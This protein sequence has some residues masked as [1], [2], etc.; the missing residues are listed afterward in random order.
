VTRTILTA[1]LLM[2]TACDKDVETA[3]PLPGGGPE[4]PERVIV[5]GIDA[6][7]YLAVLMPF[8]DVYNKTFALLDPRTGQ[9]GS[10]R[11][12]VFTNLSG[13]VTPSPDGRRVA[14]WVT[15]P[16]EGIQIARYAVEGGSPMLVMERLVELPIPQPAGAAFHWN[17]DSDRLYAQYGQTGFWIDADTGALH[18][19][20]RQAAPAQAIT[21][22]ASD[23]FLTPTHDPRRY[24]VQAAVGNT[25][26][27]LIYEDGEPVGWNAE[28]P[29]QGDGFNGQWASS[30][31]GQFMV[32]SGEGFVALTHLP[33]RTTTGLSFTATVATPYQE[34]AIHR[35]PWVPRVPQ[36]H[37]NGDFVTETGGLHGYQTRVEL[38]IGEVKKEDLYWHQQR[39]EPMRLVD[40]A[41]SMYADRLVV[42]RRLE[43]GAAALY[44]SGNGSRWQTLGFSPDG[45][46]SLLSMTGMARD[47][48]RIWPIGGA[49]SRIDHRDGSHQVLVNQDASDGMC[50][51]AMPIPSDDVRIDPFAAVA[52]LENGGL[53][54]NQVFTDGDGTFKLGPTVFGPSRI[55][56]TE[57]WHALLS[58]PDDPEGHVCFTKTA[59]PGTRHCLPV[60]G[61]YAAVLG[62]GGYAA[63]G[64]QHPAPRLVAMSRIAAPA[65]DEVMVHGVGFGASGTLHL[66]DVAVT[67]SDIVS[68]DDTRIRF[69]VAAQL[70]TEPAPV[71]VQAAAVEAT[72]S[73]VYFARTQRFVP[74]VQLPAV[75]PTM[76]PG[77][78]VTVNL[79]GLQPED[80]LAFK[81]IH[82]NGVSWDWFLTE[83]TVGTDTATFVVPE[84]A[85]VGSYAWLRVRR[86]NT[87]QDIR[88][89][90][91]P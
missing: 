57:A 7:G 67:A 39:P 37:P 44:I 9:L 50:D 87:V 23:T 69:R 77:Q 86:G 52:P 6:M 8:D 16:A 88:V 32:H 71:R 59:D 43:M 5:D 3:P 53:R 72:S 36:F 33:S 49:V 66:G 76:T 14:Y 30:P 68:W 64:A 27:Y 85:E 11:Y 24:L 70:S 35:G 29:V 46:E 90:L 31:D 42:R 1:C 55:S 38:L 58:G 17:S 51:T 41:A 62:W 34:D 25:V 12:P 74:P 15:Q 84:Q 47:G 61:G 10:D 28:R 4:T 19:Y 91:I 40:L 56:P 80:T 75:Y 45:N 82:S 13:E 83:A 63:Q 65:G 73:R 54:C 48:L 20:S 79:V 22:A 2:V 21:D 89:E 26:R 60:E 78:Q 18:Y 81:D